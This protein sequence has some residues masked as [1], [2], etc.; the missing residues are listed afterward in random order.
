MWGRDFRRTERPWGHFKTYMSNRKFTVKDIVVKPGQSLSLQS[1]RH[2]DEF[3][4]WID[5]PAPRITIGNTSFYMEA[6]REYAIPRGTKHR[7]ENPH[8][9]GSLTILEVAHGRF[10]ENDIIRYE[11]KY[12]RL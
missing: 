7:I 12:G 5:G 4:A 1:H 2:R 9:S 6:G 10:D 8:S 3:W 11:D